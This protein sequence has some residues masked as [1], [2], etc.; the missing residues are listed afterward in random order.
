[1]SIGATF[2]M[3]NESQSSQ[4]QEALEIQMVRLMT[5]GAMK[6]QSGSRLTD[7]LANVLELEKTGLLKKEVIDQ[8]EKE[9]LADDIK[10]TNDEITGGK[11]RMLPS[12]SS[13]T[14]EYSE[15]SKLGKKILGMKNFHAHNVSFEWILNML[16][17][18][19]GKATLQGEVHK[20]FATMAHKATR[21]ESVM[22]MHAS[23]EQDDFL[24][25]LYGVQGRI[26]LGNTI[27][28]V[29]LT[30]K[31]TGV[32]RMFY[33][34]GG[35]VRKDMKAANIVA[36]IEGRAD[37]SKLGLSDAE[38][39]SAKE[40][41]YA[42]LNKKQAQKNMQGKVAT[43]SD[44]TKIYYQ[45]DPK[46]VKDELIISQSQAIAYTMMFRQEGMRESMIREGY[47]EE[48][49]E[50]LENEFLTDKSKILR[51]WLTQKYDAN[52]DVVNAV[53]REQNG[54]DLPK[55]DFYSP[56]KRVAQGDVK[57]LT[58]DGDKQALTTTPGFVFDRRRNFAEMDPEVDALGI[59]NTHILQT[60]H[61][62]S[63]A[64]PIKRL[65]S[66][67]QN[68]DVKRNI[69]DYI[70]K[71]I[72]EIINERINWMADGGN[73]NAI[74]MN[75]LNKVRSAFTLSALSWNPSIGYKQLSSA[76]AYINDMGFANYIKYQKMFFG[77]FKEN[78]KEMWE[79]D[80][81]QTRFK[82]GYERDV[83]DALRM[84]GNT[85]IGRAT[86]TA[87]QDG[88]I[89]TKIGDIIPVMAGGWAM[90]QYTYDKAIKT[91]SHADAEA[92]AILQFEMTTERY[93]QASNPKDLNTF[94]GGNAFEKIMMQFL[95]SPNQYYAGVYE[96][97]LDWKAATRL[98][99]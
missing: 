44:S 41:Y 10:V 48:T 85:T 32:Y 99:D 89:F 83:K 55:I 22:N 2:V 16:S 39:E 81:V 67:F 51:D 70:G 59:Y 86:L 74:H 75:W 93:Q 42:K 1:M 5:F 71:G 66:V 58:V 33:P 23:R 30:K 6:D 7:Y 92:Q 47:T 43:L 34:E 61:Y 18:G 8:K 37:A 76:P 97:V 90:K 52:Y 57:E 65:R 4:E 56:L 14:K 60:N 40:D 31:K 49:M 77:N 64:K 36:I 84:K 46:G 20:R 15:R 96:S 79:T 78:L 9:E 63:W 29:L 19:S 50:N 62:V 73:R 53:F 28:Q 26:A 11:G 54:I 13:K 25:S 17:R 21:K 27:D 35:S 72:N 80:Y 95:T 38:V 82:E 24:K 69:N 3:A 87:L 88:M 91:M 45:T 98:R 12:E 68:T 94:Q